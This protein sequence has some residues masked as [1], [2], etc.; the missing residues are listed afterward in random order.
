MEMQRNKGNT[1]HICFAGE[2]LA[3]EGK[4]SQSSLYSSGP[5]YNAIDGNPNSNWEVGSC[6]HTKDDVH[7]GGDWI[8]EKPTKCSLLR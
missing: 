8:W 4:A 7:L 5:A 6:T 2:N 1:G 3:V